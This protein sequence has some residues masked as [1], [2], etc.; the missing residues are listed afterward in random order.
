MERTKSL[1]YLCLICCLFLVV[2]CSTPDKAAWD[3]ANRKN[4]VEGYQAYT[5]LFPNG[6]HFKEAQIKI[7][8]LTPKAPDRNDKWV[9]N[10]SVK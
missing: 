2:A 7:E 1:P 3:S 4:I 10:Q 8:L 9:K 6:K 5:Q